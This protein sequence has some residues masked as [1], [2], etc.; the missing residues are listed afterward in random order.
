MENIEEPKGEEVKKNPFSE[1][2]EK[3]FSKE[4]SDKFFESL[5][6]NQKIFVNGFISGI[7][8]SIGDRV[9]GV[10]STDYINGFHFTKELLDAVRIIV[11]HVEVESLNLKFT[12][13]VQ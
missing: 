11:Q 3:V 5:D 2:L 12:F 6:S 4:E 8:Y 10:Y 7:R 1:Y 13:I 9:V